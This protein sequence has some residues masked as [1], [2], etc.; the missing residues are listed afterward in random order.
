[1][2]HHRGGG[3]EQAIHQVALEGHEVE[4]VAEIRQRQPTWR[5]QEQVGEEV[6]GMLHARRHQPHQRGEHHDRRHGQEEINEK[7]NRPGHQ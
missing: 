1:L 4:Q 5:R 7:A 6:V 2:D 3:H